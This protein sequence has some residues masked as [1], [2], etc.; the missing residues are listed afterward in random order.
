MDKTGKK[1][2]RGMGT[3]A[4]GGSGKK[5][6]KKGKYRRVETMVAKATRIRLTQILEEFRKS[7]AGGNLN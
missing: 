7:D 4:S 1:R 6:Q 2:K 5:R 3:G